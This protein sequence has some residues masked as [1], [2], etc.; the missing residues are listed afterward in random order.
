MKN[1]ADV[2][3][4]EI[5]HKNSVLVVG[6][7]PDLQYFPDYLLDS[8]EVSDQRAAEAIYHYNRIVI[9][10][11]AEHVIA[12]KPQLAY[13]EVY[14]SEGIRALEKTIAYAKSKNL[15]VINDAKRGDIGSTS[16]AYARAFLGNGSLA[17]DM[18]T[19]NPFLGSDGYRPFI[20]E[21]GRN[22]KGLFLLVKTS[23]PSS[24][25]VQDAKL[26]NGELLYMKMADDINKIAQQTLGENNYSFI[27]AVVGATYPMDAE[28]VRKVLP[29]SIFLVPGFGA[30]G[31]TAND[32]KPFFDAKGLGAVVSSSRGIIYN[33]AKE[34]KKT[35]A[36]LYE[37]IAKAARESKDK[38]NEVRL[39]H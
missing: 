33:G 6:L 39:S 12:V 38:I 19:V 31:G 4:E 3:I 21:A 14:G 2:L 15:I 18:V 34:E 16:S 25:E 10:A 7:D 1:F 32:L 24:H 29:S 36:I 20:E 35:D 11:V 9:D 37:F 30:Q 27:G 13:Y 23:N 22:G 26:E 28:K 8:G 17:G 5:L